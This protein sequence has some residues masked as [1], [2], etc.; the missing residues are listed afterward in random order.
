MTRME[1]ELEQMGRLASRTP[2]L[3]TLSPR[4]RSAGEALC[5]AGRE[6]DDGVAGIF[7]ALARPEAF[8]FFACGGEIFIRRTGKPS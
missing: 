6:D 1:P 7:E 8:E 5:A 3:G 2:V 4:L